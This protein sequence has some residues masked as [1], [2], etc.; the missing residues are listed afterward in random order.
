MQSVANK[1]I[2]LSVIMLNVFTLSIIKLSVV[3]PYFAKAISYS[4][5]MFMKLTSGRPELDK[6]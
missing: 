6:K 5:K 4:P 3:A 1:P 2:T